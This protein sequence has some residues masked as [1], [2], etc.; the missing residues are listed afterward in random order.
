MQVV[1]LTIILIDNA[2]PD[3]KRSLLFQLTLGLF[4]R[5]LGTTKFQ[6]TQKLAI[7]PLQTLLILLPKP[8][9]G[10]ALQVRHFSVTTMQ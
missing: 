6:I 1:L 5:T 4:A 9:S 10:I 7:M 3:S 8:Q 2:I